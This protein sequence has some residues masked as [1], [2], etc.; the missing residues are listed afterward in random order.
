MKWSGEWRMGVG[1]GLGMFSFGVVYPCF[2][3]HLERVMIYDG[4]SIWHV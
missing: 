4:F 2:D 3:F 1:I